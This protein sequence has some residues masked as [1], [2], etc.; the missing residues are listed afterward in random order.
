[1][2]AIA[3]TTPAS[4]RS[5]SK[6]TLRS[7]RRRPIP[8]TRKPALGRTGDRERLRQD[9]Q[10]EFLQTLQADAGAGIGVQALNRIAAVANAVVIGG[11]DQFVELCASAL[12]LA[13]RRSR[14]AN[15]PR[16][17]RPSGPPPAAPAAVHI[18]SVEST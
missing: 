18:A 14:A 6:P 15:A 12:R 2:P 10:P 9:D 1:M 4:M 11:E 16:R 5:H 7:R 13:T 8:R 17:Y 3:A